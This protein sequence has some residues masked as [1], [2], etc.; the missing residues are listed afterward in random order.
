MAATEKDAT[1]SILDKFYNYIKTVDPETDYQG[2]IE[3]LKRSQIKDSRSD[4]LTLN[5]Q[6]TIYELTVLDDTELKKFNSIIKRLLNYLENK[7]ATIKMLTITTPK[8]KKTQDENNFMCNLLSSIFIQNIPIEPQNNRSAF[9][10]RKWLVK[11]EKCPI[12]TTRT[13][14]SSASVVLFVT[15]PKNLKD[16]FVLMTVKNKKSIRA[17]SYGTVSGYTETTTDIAHELIK[18]FPSGMKPESP[19]DTAVRELREETSIKISP[20]ALIQV[21]SNFTYNIGADRGMPPIDDFNTTFMC[22]LP[23]DYVVDNMELNDTENCKIE[24]VPYSEAL[25]KFKE[26]NITRVK[27]EGSYL[28]YNNHKSALETKDVSLGWTESPCTS[29]VCSLYSSLKSKMGS[30]NPSRVDENTKSTKTKRLTI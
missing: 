10:F 21:M 7:D 24:L 29:T 14:R 17:G 22:I 13:Y 27:I 3:I 12:P 30:F 9:T 25:N 16:P 6:S 28:V 19:K 8:P 18:C 15:N 26:N 11:T 23:Y 4:N 1:A 2:V 20:D 5:F